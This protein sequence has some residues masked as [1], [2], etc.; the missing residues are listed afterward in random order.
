MPLLVLSIPLYLVYAEHPTG[1]DD[2]SIILDQPETGTYALTPSATQILTSNQTALI[3]QASSDSLSI[4]VQKYSS[5]YATAG[6]TDHF[7]YDGATLV[8]ANGDGIIQSKYASYDE[9]KQYLSTT[10]LIDDDSFKAI[11]DQSVLVVLDAA[12]HGYEDSNGLSYRWSIQNTDALHSVIPPLLTEPTDSILLNAK[13][14][15]TFVISLVVRDSTTEIFSENTSIQVYNGTIYKD[16]YTLEST[17]PFDVDTPIRVAID[18]NYEPFEMYKPN[19][20]V[21][22]VTGKYIEQFESLTDASFV[23]VVPANFTVALDAVKNRDA[24]VMFWLSDVPERSNFMS[25]T[26]AV[27]FLD[28][29]VLVTVNDLDVTSENLADYTVAIISDYAHKTILDENFPDVSY[30]EYENALEAVRALENNDVD[31]FISDFTI[32]SYYAST[33]GVE[34]VKSNEFT[35]DDRDS[36]QGLTIGY[37]SDSPELGVFLQ[38]TLNEISDCTRAELLN[39]IINPQ[40]TA[41]YTQKNTACYSD[42]QNNDQTNYATTSDSV[43]VPT[44]EAGPKVIKSAKTSSGGGSGST[45][46]SRVCGGVLCSEA[47]NQPSDKSSSV[48][49]HLPDV[50]SSDEPTPTVEPESIPEPK[51]PLCGS[52]TELVDGQCRAMVEP[53][54]EPEYMP[55]PK[56]P[57]CGSGTELVDGQCRAIVEPTVE[58]KPEKSW[59]DN[60]IEAILSFFANLV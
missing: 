46:S 16:D 21:G 50:T 36:V 38:N 2:F 32:A 24:D 10:S 27:L 51:E 48:S 15:D 41:R 45:M 25:F 22:G 29:D 19:G 30:V 43:V 59:F 34:L 4:D 31:V 12:N 39:D 44:S 49:D 42:S 54:V 55:E 1:T 23:F 17:V 20:D 26:N 11:W 37:R 53:T 58:P 7:F 60:F 47:S 56:E 33:I 40:D 9:L 3:I 52:G 28:G 5:T 18:P 13:T 6:G 14:T 57:L 8:S 35:Y